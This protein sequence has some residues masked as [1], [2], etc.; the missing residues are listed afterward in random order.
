MVI[1]YFKFRESLIKKII[2]F[3]I[4][5]GHQNVSGWQCESYNVW[6]LHSVTAIKYDC[7]TV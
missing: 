6:R 3:Y 1:A 5:C 2:N 7:Y 4:N